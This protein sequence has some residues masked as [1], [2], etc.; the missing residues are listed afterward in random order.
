MDL[1]RR[2]LHFEDD[3]VHLQTLSS[4]RLSIRSLLFLLVLA[5]LLPAAAVSAWFVHNELE[6]ALA[7]ARGTVRL[8]ANNAAATLQL[9]LRDQQV[10]LKRFAERPG[11]R[12]LDPEKFDAGVAEYLRLHPEFNNLGVRDRQARLIFSGRPGGASPPE[13]L[14]EFPWFKEGIASGRFMAGDAFLGRL[15]GR[16]VTVLTQPVLDERGDAAGLLHMALDLLALNQRVTASVPSDAI[17]AV[18]DRQN[19][20]LLRSAEPERWLGSPAPSVLSPS[21][22]AEREGFVVAGGPDGVTR[23]YAFVT[24]DDTGWRVVAG[25]PQDQA[26]AE[27]RSLQRGALLIGIGILLL[28]GLLAWYLGRGI[29][30]PVGALSRAAA[31]VAGGDNGARATVAGPIEIR[32]VATQFNH[33]VEA[34]AGMENA[35]RQSENSLAVTLQSIADAVIATDLG[36]RITRMNAAA[37]RLTGW[38]TAEALGRPLLEVFRVVDS[39]TRQPVADPVQRV[40]GSGMAVGLANHAA[41]LARD[42]SECQIADSAAPIRDDAGRTLGV[43]LVFSDVTARYRAEQAERASAEVLRLRERAL[44]EV[45][46]GVILTDAQARITYVNPGFERLTGYAAS[47]VMGRTPRFLQGGA[48]SSETAAEIARAVRAGKGFHGEILNHRKDGSPMWVALDISPLHDEQGVLTGYVGAQ[49]DVS[50]RKQAEAERRLL[51]TQL[52][53]SQKMEAIGTLAGGIAHDFNNMLGA[54]LGNVA[55]ARGD[56]PAGHSALT[57]LEQIKKASLRARELVQQI[58]AF[59]RRQPQALFN[60]PLRPLVEEASALLRTTLPARVNLECVLADTPVHAKVDGTQI[61][62]VLMNLCTNAWHALQDSS[63]VIP[64]GLDEVTLDATQAL[65][66]GALPASRYA[67][68]WVRDTG[69]GMDAV[70]CARIFEPFFTTKPSGHGTGLGLSM[71]HGI[72]AAHGGAIKVDS[73]VGKGSTFHLYF[74]AQPHDAQTLAS[75]MT[76]PAGLQ[77]EGEHVLYVDDDEVMLLMVE[78]L[79]ERAGYRATCCPNAQEALALVQAS[80]L[81]VDIV[82]S[83]YNMPGMSGLELAEALARVRPDLPLVISSGYLSEELVS[84]AERLGVR[85]LLQKQNTLEELVRLV[86]RILAQ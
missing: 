83:D 75:A 59:S 69:T 46:Q 5:I 39:Q 53:E 57:S 66:A 24:M 14:R 79:L 45:S 32:A 37:E 49:R 17:V 15:S 74:P 38:P 50:E 11:V 52:R 61:Q 12:A 1:Y 47:E 70:T 28:A 71:V 78:R 25:V 65:A 26:L 86:R 16:W 55:L 18:T 64:V 31:R 20:Y 81:A 68:L 62:Q 60:Q 54:I 21:E 27:Y 41:L 7:T 36:G 85:H 30:G 35:L 19:R 67:H 51:E 2:C 44:A 3:S 9:T 10:M 43:V 73:A 13:E 77:G 76:Q 40:L 23:L 8:L 58:L 72:V 42:G 80:P 33:M 34:R 29:V 63:G 48:T 22:R 6:E 82:V 56:L 84:G 4:V